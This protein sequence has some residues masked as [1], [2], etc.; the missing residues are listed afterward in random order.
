[1]S[2]QLTQPARVAAVA[3]A[4][5][6]AADYFMLGILGS[7]PG[8][9]GSRCAR[10]RPCAPAALSA[11]SRV[12]AWQARHFLARGI[13]HVEFQYCSYA[14]CR[15]RCDGASGA[16]AALRLRP[17]VGVHTGWQRGVRAPGRAAPGVHARSG[18][19]CMP[20]PPHSQGWQPMAYFT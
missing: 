18:A 17:L 20:P 5:L 9:P 3:A 15:R 7:G 2:A 4:G 14:A 16:R 13:R 8:T 12:R 10:P 6:L 19:S 1:M 11:H